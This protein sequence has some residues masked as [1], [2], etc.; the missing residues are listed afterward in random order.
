MQPGSKGGYYTEK[1]PKML[2]LEWCQQQKRPKPRYKV[3]A[4]AANTMRCKVSFIRDVC[5]KVVCI[6]AVQLCYFTR[7]ALQLEAVRPGFDG[8]SGSESCC[9][10]HMKPD[11][12]LLC[13]SYKERCL[14]FC[15]NL[16]R[17]S[18]RVS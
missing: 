12:F 1:S 6:A 10:L 18:A 17:N 7:V 9:R 13:Q 4:A 15:A 8:F 16:T 5:T 3:L 2:L 11:W 14:P